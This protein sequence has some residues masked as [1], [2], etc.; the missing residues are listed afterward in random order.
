MSNLFEE[1]KQI[2]LASRFVAKDLAKKIP[3]CEF[4]FIPDQDHFISR[5]AV[6]SKRILDRILEFSAHAGIDGRT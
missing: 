1:T 5:N 4:Y 6:L 2:E 3:N